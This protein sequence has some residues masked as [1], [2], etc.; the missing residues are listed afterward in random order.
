[1][2]HTFILLTALLLA[3][4][5]ALHAANPAAGQA[6]DPTKIPIRF[7]TPG[8]GQL[9]LGVYDDSGM[10]IRSLTYASGVDGG[11]QT[12]EWDGTTDL[13]L[14]AKPGTY[15]ARGVWFAEPLKAS[16]KMKV[17][18]SG[19]PPYVL[20]NGLGAIAIDNAKSIRVKNVEVEIPQPAGAA[21][22]AW[23]LKDD[24]GNYVEPGT[25]Y[26]GSRARGA[27]SAVWMSWSASW[28]RSG[29]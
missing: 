20:D 25:R 18:V 4:L 19:D 5:A 6:A 11:K 14:P 10:L 2:Q 9:S 3:P 22:V 7:T 8:K 29:S 27:G 12:L 17:G 23:D 15:A 24:F 28:S 26:A 1:M 13:G 16:F 21:Q